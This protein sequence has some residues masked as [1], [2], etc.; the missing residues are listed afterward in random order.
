MRSSSHLL[1]AFACNQVKKR[2]LSIIM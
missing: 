2:H 1:I